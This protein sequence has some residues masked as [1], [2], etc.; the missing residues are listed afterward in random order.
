MWN[1]LFNR[2]QNNDFQYN[3]ITEYSRKIEFST[4]TLH[5][6]LSKNKYTPVSVFRYEKNRELMSY[7]YA[8]RHLQR[9]KTLRHPNILTFVD[10]YE[11]ENYVLIV[12][13][14]V[15][16]LFEYLE[17]EED[18]RT[19][20]EFIRWGLMNITKALDFCHR[21]GKFYHNNV[22]HNAVFVNDAGEWKLGEF[23]FASESNSSRSGSRAEQALNLT[24]VD[25][26]KSLKPWAADVAGLAVLI[27]E[28]YNRSTLTE[29]PLQNSQMV[30]EGLREVLSLILESEETP[31]ARELLTQGR[32][33]GSFF[34]NDFIDRILFLEAFHTKTPLEKANFF[35]DFQKCIGQ[36]P[37][38]VAKFKIYPLLVM[39]YDYG[40]EG[41]HLLPTLLEFYKK[42]SQYG[43]NLAE[44]IVK[45]FKSSSRAT[46]KML[47]DHTEQYINKIPQGIINDEIFPLF[48]AGFRDGSAAIRKETIKS[49]QHYVTK[50]HKNRI[51]RELLPL[52]AGCLV[53]ETEGEI[54]R[55]SVETI[56]NL[57]AHID[58]N[59]RKNVLLAVL[60]KAMKDTDAATRGTAVKYL[61]QTQEFFTPEDMSRKILPAL[62]GLVL[63]RE[64]NVR[65][66][67]FFV[68]R[69]LLG[70]LEDI[71]FPAE[72][73]EEAPSPSQKTWTEWAI[74]ALPTTFSSIFKEDA[75]Q[76]DE[77]NMIEKK[78][79]VSAENNQT[80][81]IEYK[82]RETDERQIQ[83]NSV[84][85]GV[86]NNSNVGTSVN[87]NCEDQS[88][89]VADK[90]ENEGKQEKED[91]NQG[92]GGNFSRRARR[93]PKRLAT[94]INH[95]ERRPIE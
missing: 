85:E 67:V 62:C 44:F 9:L 7:D 87:K 47:L 29:R 6:A 42:R 24:I 66:N 94:R 91:D 68:M 52:L 59:T 25:P 78:N 45:L 13:E 92:Q 86:R 2:E 81:D 32:Q 74:A 8:A 55:I 12:T 4:F 15:I 84:G 18:G 30:P 21:E 56:G 72:A 28:V 43:V 20:S 82:K 48:A 39:A 46:R 71:E 50:L 89:R 33:N 73:G 61:L 34:Q 95:K 79:T 65:S 83:V 38:H 19:R 10:S 90:M 23:G 88:G 63:D 93:G 58:P 54:R 77:R 16:P 76:K 60:T 3:Y 64:Q 57:A 51:N 37:E 5:D 40:C 35:K 11:D 70:K 41:T 1:I 14:R 26:R 22:G 27:A 69:E 53:E 80:K 49:V 31:S 75:P 17:N 36:V